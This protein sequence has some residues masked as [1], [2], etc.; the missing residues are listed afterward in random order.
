MKKA[1]LLIAALILAT[2]AVFSQSIG[3]NTTNSAPD[4]SAAVDVNFTDKGFLPPRMSEAQRN[5]IPSPVA[6]LMVWCSNCGANGEAQVYN[7]TTWTNLLGA[8]AATFVC[9]TSSITVTH[10]A[11]TV[12]PV[13]KTVTYGTVTNIPGEPTKCWITKN[14]GATNQA[15]AVDDATEEAAGWY[16]QFN[17][18]QGYKHKDG[19]RTPNTV[20]ISSISENSDW[21]AANDP[22]AIELGG[23]WRLPTSTEWEHIDAT[24]GWT[25]WNGPFASGLKLNGAG[26]IYHNDGTLS[27]PGGTGGY[28]SSTQYDASNAWHLGY[29]PSVSSMFNL[30]KA[31]GFTA[32]CIKD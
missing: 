8:T 1:N 5:A 23:G 11:G 20:W 32:R 13:D 2:T 14:L 30:S 18:K 12:A 17:L 25:N 15:T 28:W 16:W 27:Y 24:G 9:G 29:D 19:L 4:P 6:G 22:C 10:M 3:I 21:V 26:Y 7:G 31:D